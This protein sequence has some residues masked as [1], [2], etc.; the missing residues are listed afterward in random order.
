MSA[1]SRVLREDGKRSM[2][3]VTNIIYI[4]FCFSN[5]SEFHPII[6][7]NKIGDMCLRVADQESKRFDIWLQD[8]KTLE[9]KAKETPH[10]KTVLAELE[11]EHKKIQN[12]MRKQDQLLFGNLT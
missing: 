9:E 12:R 10:D 7:S 8:I 4:F 6:T 5:F 1:L 3:L 11:S 2:E